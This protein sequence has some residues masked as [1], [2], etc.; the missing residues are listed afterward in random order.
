MPTARRLDRAVP[1]PGSTLAMRCGRRWRP[2]SPSRVAATPWRPASRFGRRI[3]S[4]SGL[5]H[6]QAERSR[7]APCALNDHS[8]RRHA[9]R[10]GR[11][12]GLVPALERAGPFGSGQ[13]EPVFVFP[14]HRLIEAREVGSGGHMR[15][16]LRAAMAAHWGNCLPRSG[17]AAREMH[18]R[19]P[20][21]A[22]L[23]VA[24]TLSIDRWGGHEKAE[25][26]IMDAARPE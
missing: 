15:V 22:T 14:Q 12:A 24:G 26:R 1:C 23:H 3:W 11:P 7:V 17:S 2:G 5:R 4:F 25:L 13:P 18:S 16:K 19:T 20:S 8:H 6:R 9:D 10:G 21:A